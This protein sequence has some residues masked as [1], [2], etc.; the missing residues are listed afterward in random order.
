[1]IIT[2]SQKAHLDELSQQ[3][4][5]LKTKLENLNITG[6][7][8]YIAAS[9]GYLNQAETCFDTAIYRLTKTPLDNR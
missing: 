6:D 2:T 8:G 3:I 1:M 7:G 5:D 9:A 4:N